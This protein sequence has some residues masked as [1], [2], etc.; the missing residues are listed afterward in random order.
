VKSLENENLERVRSLKIENNH[1]VI[2]E[3]P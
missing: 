2:G 3:I 1:V